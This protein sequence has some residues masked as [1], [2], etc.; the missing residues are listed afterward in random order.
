MNTGRKVLFLTNFAG[1]ALSGTSPLLIARMYAKRLISGFVILTLMLSSSVL[2]GGELTHQS[3]FKIERNKNANIIQYDAQIG[4]NGKLDSRE[5][6]TAYW[7]RLAEQGQVEK[8]S[9][10]QKKFAYG[11]KAKFNAK[12]DSAELKMA[13]KIGRAITVRLVGDRYRALAPIDSKLSYVEVI[14]IHDLGSGMSVKVEYIELHGT[15]LQTGEVRY[16]RFVP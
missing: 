15:D 13:A 11:F 6:V 3:L 14:Y 4:D 5:P 9:F 1:L 12:E 2:Y 16:E 7:I 8:L 10:V